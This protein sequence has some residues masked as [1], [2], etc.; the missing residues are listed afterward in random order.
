MHRSHSS[1]RRRG[2]CTCGAVLLV[3]C[4][5]ALLSIGETAPAEPAGAKATEEIAARVNGD[6]ITVPELNR[7]FL[8]HVKV[9][10]STVQADPRAQEIRRQLLDTLIDRA[11]LVQQ[12][13]KQRM[14]VPPQALEEAVQV[15]IQRFPARESFE[16][17][18]QAEGLTFEGITQD[19]G[20]QLLR[21]QLVQN[22]IVE[23]ISL[24]PND[25]PGF[26]EQHQSRYMAQEQVRA[27]HILI[28]VPPDMGEADEAK[29]R[30]RANKARARARKGESFAKLAQEL[31]E[32]TSRSNGG[33]L[34]F[35]KRGQMVGP[36]EES[37]FA[38]KVGEISGLVRTPF[39]YHIIKVEERTS[40]K[41]LP[42][43][44]VKEQVQEDLMRE[45]TVAR[46][47]E[48][49]GGLRGKATI[50]VSFP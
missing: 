31:S 14:T 44:E 23:K 10:Y 27:R 41:Q 34:G 16:E 12:A 49:M 7:I 42:F 48:Y 29:L 24:N 20:D 38:L 18:L 35:F 32:D 40:A 30:D 9:P 28:K 17:A 5:A 26:Y 8:A 11:L 2:F 21:K 6:P 50:E 46:Y 37:A 45:H 33:D 43:E 15:L 13:K 19:L 39:G 36:F 1:D 47:Q 25:I 22:E 4:L 3:I